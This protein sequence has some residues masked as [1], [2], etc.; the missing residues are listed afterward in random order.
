[1]YVAG[2]AREFPDDVQQWLARPDHRA[3]A[4]PSV[5]EALGVPR[6]PMLPRLFLRLGTMSGTGAEA[7]TGPSV[8]D[9]DSVLATARGALAAAADR[10]GNGKDADAVDRAVERWRG[11]VERVLTPHA[12]SSSKA[13]EDWR[14]TDD[15]RREREVPALWATGFF[16][17]LTASLM[18]AS[19]DHFRRLVEGGPVDYVL[20]A[21]QPVPE[22]TP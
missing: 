11:T 10:V 22:E 3:V 1:M 17:E 14:D 15:T 7:V 4:V 2:S 12:R 6:P 18:D 5:Y 13:R 20:D 19:R 9:V 21:D 16:D 8:A